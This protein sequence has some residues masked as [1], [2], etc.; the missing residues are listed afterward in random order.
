MIKKIILFS[1]VLLLSWS[2]IGLPLVVAAGEDLEYGGSGGDFGGLVPCDGADDCDWKAFFKLLNNLLTF[3]VW[4]SAFVAGL[5]FAWV[6]VMFLRY[7]TNSSKR[8]E[9]KQWLWKILI[10]FGAILIAQL[11]VNTIFNFLVK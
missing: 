1:L 6:G 5:A 2:R 7:S 8:E 4:I 3:A 10:G 9:A 11:L